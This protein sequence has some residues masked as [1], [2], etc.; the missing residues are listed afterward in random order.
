MVHTFYDFNFVANKENVNIDFRVEDDPSLLV[1]QQMSLLGKRFF[2]E[3]MNSSVIFKALIYEETRKDHLPLRDFCIFTQ[4]KMIKYT[5]NTYDLSCKEKSQVN[6]AIHNA[7]KN[8]MSQ[9]YECLVKTPQKFL[10]EMGVVNR[11]YSELCNYYTMYL[12]K[13]TKDRQQPRP[14]IFPRIALSQPAAITAVV[15]GMITSLLLSVITGGIQ[16]SIM[17]GMS[18]ACLSFIVT[19][20]FLYKKIRLVIAKFVIGTKIT[21]KQLLDCIMQKDLREYVKKDRVIHAV[22]WTVRTRL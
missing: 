3:G 11:R 19:K 6:M 15:V 9:M 13:Q 17:L 14:P 7:Q 16:G 10:T 1:L 2:R 22:C 8:S 18:L 21:P 4:M 20:R 5:K 12:R